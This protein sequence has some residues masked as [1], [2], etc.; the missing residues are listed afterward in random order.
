MP[1]TCD[2][3]CFSCPFDDCIAPEEEMTVYEEAEAERRDRDA[4]NANCPGDYDDPVMQEKKRE[5]D[6]KRRWR[7]ENREKVREY[8]R[9]YRAERAEH[10]RAMNREYYKKNRERIDAY[11][12]AKRKLDKGR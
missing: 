7:E 6:R 8:H 1:N 3:N 2:H 11:R 12:A 4:W 10:Y 9:V 5:S